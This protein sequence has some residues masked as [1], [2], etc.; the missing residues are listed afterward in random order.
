VCQSALIQLGARFPPCMKAVQG[1]PFDTQIACLYICHAAMKYPAELTCG[2]DTGLND[3]SNPPTEL[4]SLEDICAFGG[5]N[6]AIPNQ[7]FRFITP[8]FIHGL[9]NAH[10]PSVAI[11]T[12]PSS[13]HHPLTFEHASTVDFLG[14]GEHALRYRMTGLIV[15]YK[16]EREMGSAGFLLLYMAAGIFG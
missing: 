7:W 9:P 8:I 16:I 6:G 3:T 11:L 14:S 12:T 5:F 4:C 13:R 15:V 2:C 1:I 10:P